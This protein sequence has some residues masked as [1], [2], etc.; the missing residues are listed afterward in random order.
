LAFGFPG[1]SAEGIDFLRGLARNNNRD[2]FLPRKHIF[3]EQVKRPMHELVEA[4]NRAMAAFAP[5]FVTDPTKAVFRI[6]RD[7]RFS[8]DKKPYK[9]HIAANFRRR[10][11]GPHEGGGYYFAISHK[12]VAIGGGLYMPPPETLLAVR[13]HI[14]G[15]HAELR[16][17]TASRMIRKLLGEMQ[18]EQLSRVPKGFPADHPAADL[19]RFK[20]FVFYRELKPEIATTPKLLRDIL[21][22]FRAITPFVEFLNAPVAHARKKID[23]RDLL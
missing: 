14:A 16:K 1:F 10:G 2:W 21:E 23:A 13:N 7:T 4:V 5:D 11:G 12:S 19:L 3:E 6:Y 9:E 15:H 20:S 22:R 18:G 8:K 17:V